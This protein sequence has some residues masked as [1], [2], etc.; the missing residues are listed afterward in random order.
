M[1]KHELTCPL[2]TS[3]EE[4]DAFVCAAYC[5]HPLWFVY[6]KH[7]HTRCI[8]ASAPPVSVSLPRACRFSRPCS[9]RVRYVNLTRSFA[10]QL[11]LCWHTFLRMQTHDPDI[12]GMQQGAW[13]ICAGVKERPRWRSR[14]QR[15]KSFRLKSR[16]RMEWGVLVSWLFLD[17]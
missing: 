7:T 5:L 11:P 9:L 14:C 6:R 15:V 4:S 3:Q 2:C 17:V 10:Q 13:C 8:R 12:R 1:A 16:S